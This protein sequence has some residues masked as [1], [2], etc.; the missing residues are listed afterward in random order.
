VMSISFVA[1]SMVESAI[2]RFA[3]GPNL[4]PIWV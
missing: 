4:I 3:S 2:E 1:M